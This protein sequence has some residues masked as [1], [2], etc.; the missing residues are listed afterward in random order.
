MAVVGGWK[1]GVSA[2][3]RRIGMD[4]FEG[5]LPLMPSAVAPAVT[6]LSAYSIWTRRPLGLKVVREKE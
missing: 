4:R 2:R 6:A 1:E 5:G 3:R